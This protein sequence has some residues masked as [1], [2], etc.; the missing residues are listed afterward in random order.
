MPKTHLSVRRMTVGAEV[1][2]LTMGDE[3]DPGIAAALYEAWLVHGI[4]LFKNVATTEQHLALSRC[5]G[6]L[7]L[8]PFPEVRSEENPLLIEIGGRKR[9]PAHVYDETEVLVNRIAWHRDT[10]Y[11]PDICKGAMLRMVEVPSQGGETLFAD[12]AL[13]YDA[14]PPEMKTRLAGLEY[15]GTLRITP[16]DQTRPGAFWKSV[17]L[18]TQEEDPEGASLN[19]NNSAATARYPS[20]V[21]PA[22]LVHPESG[23]KCIF[24]S[25][26]YVDS[27]LG[28]N[29]SESDELLEYLVSHMLEPRFVYKHRWSLNESI[30]WDNRR[31]MHAAVGNKPGEPRR[32]L[33]TTLAGSLRTGRL[34]DQSSRAPELPMAAD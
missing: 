16:M 29:Q 12:T 30:V 26:T 13:A 22:V 28:M 4:L 3:S 2:G 18:A 7:E 5:F 34:F 15:K 19:V 6:E 21:H 9:A 20:V 14:L 10:A 31:F 33:R 25:P 1:V 32:G 11:T 23:R 27:F 17:R 8:H 24:L